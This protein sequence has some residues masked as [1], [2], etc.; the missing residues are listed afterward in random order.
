MPN[1]YPKAKSATI[2]KS[3][4]KTTI[5]ADLNEPAL[6]ERKKFSRGTKLKLVLMGIAITALVIY[7]IWDIVFQGPITSLLSNRD[8]LVESVRSFGIFA[9]LLYIIFQVIQTV[10]APIPGQI[11]GSVGGFIFGP[12]GVLWTTIGSLIGCFIVF[13]IARRF[14]RPLLEKIFKKSS[15]EKFDFIIDAKGS[16][17]ILFAIFLL[18]GFPDDVVCYI[19]GLTRLPIPR[20]MVLVGLGRLPTIALTNYLGSG[21]GGDHI[22]LVALASMVSVAVLGLVVWKRE[23]IIKFLKGEHKKS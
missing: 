10:A 3:N 22:W 16:S 8:Q 21:L 18:P 6:D 17:L 1:K 15:I 20:L 2:R 12:W 5:N 9:P 11:V 14:G 13:K 19:A 4:T 7:L 23:W